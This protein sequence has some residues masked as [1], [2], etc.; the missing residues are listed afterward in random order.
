MSQWKEGVEEPPKG[1]LSVCGQLWRRRLGGVQDPALASPSLPQ[2]RCS[3]HT[4]AGWEDIVVP[5]LTPQLGRLRT[6]EGSDLLK[7][8]F[9][10]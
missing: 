1:H 2:S 7:A 4:R 5:L 8:T 6:R 10:E 9:S 3:D